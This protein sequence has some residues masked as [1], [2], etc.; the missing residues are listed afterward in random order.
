MNDIP[1]ATLDGIIAEVRRHQTAKQ[2][3]ALPPVAKAQPVTHAKPVAVAKAAPAPAQPIAE[4]KP[5][6]EQLRQRNAAIVAKALDMF[7][8]GEITAADIAR[9]LAFRQQVE[10]LNVA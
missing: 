7:H 2:T 6:A 9:L 1:T 5:T 10:S 4:A 8:A 3:V